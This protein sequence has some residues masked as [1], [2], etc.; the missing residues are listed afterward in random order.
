MFLHE[1]RTFMM[2]FL[3]IRI[4]WKSLTNTVKFTPVPE[5]YSHSRFYWYDSRIS[6]KLFFNSDLKLLILNVWCSIFEFQ[7]LRRTISDQFSGSISTTLHHSDWKHFLSTAR[8]WTRTSPEL[9]SLWVFSAACDWTFNVS[10]SKVT[11]L[12]L[13]ETAA[14]LQALIELRLVHNDLL[15]QVQNE[16]TFN[17]TGVNF[18]I[19]TGVVGGASSWQVI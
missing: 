13:I 7:Y 1:L 14:S 6:L 12:I 19:V 16:S 10:W 4:F 2:I 15:E 17:D 18:A 9:K 8:H 3:D 5:I 11:N